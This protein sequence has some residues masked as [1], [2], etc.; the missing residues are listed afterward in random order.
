MKRILGILIPIL[1]LLVTI[2]GTWLGQFLGF[3]PDGLAF[4]LWP[5]LI[6]VLFLVFGVL[7]LLK[8]LKPLLWPLGAGFLVQTF[9]IIMLMSRVFESPWEPLWYTLGTVGGVIVLMLLIWL[10]A[11][12]RA[13]YLER[14]MADGL[15]GFGGNAEDLARIRDEMMKALDMLRRAGRGRNAIYDLPWSLKKPN[16]D[17]SIQRCSWIFTLASP[18]AGTSISFW[19]KRYSGPRL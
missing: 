9:G 16:S 12:I 4:W 14:S 13:R 8:G 17:K 2:G 15:S 3:I 5:S 19:S 11:S 10:F 18:L 7:A 1:I 6:A